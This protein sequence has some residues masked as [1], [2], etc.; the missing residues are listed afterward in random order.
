MKLNFVSLIF[1]LILICIVLIFYHY[2]YLSEVKDV[3]K[4]VKLYEAI[5][6]DPQ[7]ITL[8]R[9]DDETFA[10]LIYTVGEN[11][12]SYNI[13]EENHAYTLDGNIYRE[14]EHGTVT[15]QEESFKITGIDKTFTCPSPFKWNGEICILP[16]LCTSK[17]E[18]KG[19]PYEYSKLV[20][21]TEHY[22]HEKLYLSCPGDVLNYCKDN[23]I[24]VGL[25]SIPIT[26]EPCVSFD[27]CIKNIDGYRHSE[28]ID[29]YD[30][31][32]NEFYICENGKSKLIKCDGDLLYD[33]ENNSCLESVCDNGM[34]KERDS[35][36][37]YICQNGVY[38]IVNCENG[39]DETGTNCA[40]FDYCQGFQ[41]EYGYYDDLFGGINVIRYCKDSNI[42]I[43]AP[44]EEEAE[45]QIETI[46]EE[47]CD[48]QMN[49]A[50]VSFPR[51]ALNYNLSQYDRLLGTT[52]FTYFDIG[53]S[54]TLYLK[55]DDL[56]IAK[57]SD[58]GIAGFGKL[59]G[60]YSIFYL[61][62]K[63]LRPTA[64]YTFL[65]TDSGSTEGLNFTII[66]VDSNLKPAYEKVTG[67]FTAALVNEN[68]TFG[69]IGAYFV[70]EDDRFL[71]LVH[72]MY[73]KEQVE[74][75]KN[76]PTISELN[77]IY[78][79]FRSLMKYFI[80]AKVDRRPTEEVYTLGEYDETIDEIFPITKREFRVGVLIPETFSDLIGLSNCL[81][82][83]VLI[84]EYLELK[85][86]SLSDDYTLDDLYVMRAS[87]KF[88]Q[89][90]A[91]ILYPKEILL[92]LFSMTNEFGESI[93]KDNL[94]VTYRDE[95]IV[96]LVTTTEEN[97]SNREYFIYN[98]VKSVSGNYKF[99]DSNFKF[100]DEFFFNVTV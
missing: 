27:I 62:D 10:N 56:K 47:A 23:K 29:D 32:D 91:Y 71:P 95:T 7:Q 86:Y 12:G 100:K 65:D 33:E 64:N 80:V 26:D 46:N 69:T 3:D 57:T 2:Y 78:R 39:V 6:V 76:E 67:V 43:A 81:I 66:K 72:H 85:N 99:T 9:K 93:K 42:E 75:I 4:I 35:D 11:E 59:N 88:G 24:Y 22:Y 36:S 31:K 61:A 28:K 87:G 79:Y 17:V 63:A 13:V 74:F 1:S 60:T 5:G 45:F 92:N 97:I 21:S 25:E 68:C 54:H 16:S 52:L 19:I 53:L 73:D 41:D 84:S 38:R 51:Y 18:Y 14:K 34:K 55:L 44:D 50:T 40:S 70:N 82:G 30:L 77:N 58:D 15:E 20:Y 96:E 37:Y 89:F 98:G 49:V 90:N 48:N 94:I 8:Y 83:V